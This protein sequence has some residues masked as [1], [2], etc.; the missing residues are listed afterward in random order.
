MHE[1]HLAASQINELIYRGI[2]REIETR[3]FNTK[4]RIS[5]PLWYSMV[6]AAPPAKGK[7]NDKRKDAK[8]D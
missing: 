8:D 6:D 2:N 1:V 7:K 3:R 4:R 5:N